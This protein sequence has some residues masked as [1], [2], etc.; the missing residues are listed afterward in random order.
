MDR[1]RELR[2]PAVA[3]VVVIDDGV[4]GGQHLS[5]VGPLFLSSQ[6]SNLSSMTEARALCGHF[7]AR[8]VEPQSA[9][10]NPKSPLS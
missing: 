5:G 3:H 8:F 4:G 10:R 1:C 9:F 7:A 6:Q 2:L